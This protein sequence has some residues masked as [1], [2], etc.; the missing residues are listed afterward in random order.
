MKKH[1]LL[2]GHGGCYNHGAEAAT[3][4]TIQLL[5]ECSPGCT[6]TVATHFAGQDKEF[7]LPADTLLQSNMAGKSWGE[8]YAAAVASIS[9]T[10]TCLHVG[11]DNYCYPNWERYAFIHK[12]ALARGARSILWSCSLEPSMLN[13]E[14]AEVLR[15][16]HAIF[17]RESTTVE[18]L[19]KCGC[20]GV[21]QMADIAF[22]LDAQKTQLPFHNYLAV[23]IS[24]LVVRRNPKVFGA[25]QKLIDYVLAETD[26]NIALVPHVVM[27]MDND[28]DILAEL[29]LASDRVA[30]I[31][32]QLSAREYKYIISKARFCAAT[33]THA[34]IAAYSSCIPTLAVGYS[35][36]ASG[37]AHDLGMES[38]FLQLDSIGDEKSMVEPFKRLLLEE[39]KLKNQLEALMPAYRKT[40]TGNAVELI[41]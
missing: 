16:H 14:M 3:R 34:C 37:I 39:T 32:G 33:R 15:T 23:N 35:A 12:A 4:C 21:V 13:A 31:S 18:A 25:F 10:T 30:M 40:A 20:S 19:E 17:A 1:Y 22:K 26:L 9:P 24:P 7:A 2:Y 6:I 29:N 5:R 28:C 8:M 36:K 27:P 11:G 41:K 38:Q